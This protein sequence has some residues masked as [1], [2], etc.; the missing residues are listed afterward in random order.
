[1][2]KINKVDFYCG[3]FLSYLITNK[4]EPTLFNTTE[5]SKVVQF[6]LRNTDYNVYVK[7]VSTSKIST[8]KGKQYTKWDINFQKNERDYLLNDFCIANKKN[9]VVLVCANQDFKD[10]Y[11]AVLSY[12][13]AVK[14]LGK[15]AINTQYRITVKHQKKSPNSYCYGTA[16][17]EENA[18]RIMYNVDAFFGFNDKVVISS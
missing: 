6:L 11:F 13:D 7:Y 5:K 16:I 15:D 10:T 18:I 9:I 14:C 12:D 2:G 17:D 4:V 3:A 1:M 8:K